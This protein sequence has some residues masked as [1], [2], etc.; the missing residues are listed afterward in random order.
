MKTIA[1]SIFSLLVTL[2]SYGQ[3]STIQSDSVVNVDPVEYIKKE[4]IGGKL[5]FNL[6]LE[7]DNKALYL[8]DRVAYNKNDFDIF[9]WGQAVKSHGVSGIKKAAKLWEEINGRELTTLEKK[10][11]TKGIETEID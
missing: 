8:Y 3:T 9:L 4:T 2:C 6:V 1:L 7:K 5:D 10:A 11:L